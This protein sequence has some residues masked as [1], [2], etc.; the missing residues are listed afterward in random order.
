MFK[1][2]QISLLNK[3]FEELDKK[4]NRNW[5]DLLYQL[6]YISNSV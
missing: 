1:D 5:L 2:I 6:V 3:T 4:P